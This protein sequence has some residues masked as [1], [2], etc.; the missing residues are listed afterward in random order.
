MNRSPLNE[1]RQG[2]QSIEMNTFNTGGKAAVYLNDDAVCLH[3]PCWTG[4]L[5]LTVY[6]YSSS[7]L[8]Y[9]HPADC[10]TDLVAQAP[11]PAERCPFTCD[12]IHTVAHLN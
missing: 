5:S 8:S 11:S 1:R 6:L 7:E 12:L 3:S 9:N 4:L 10:E 2:R